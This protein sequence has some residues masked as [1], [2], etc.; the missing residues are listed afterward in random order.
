MQREWDSLLDDEDRGRVVKHPVY[1]LEV[2]HGDCE[3]CDVS[4]GCKCKRPDRRHWCKRHKQLE[5]G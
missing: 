2:G 1:R 3:E 4:V 5:M